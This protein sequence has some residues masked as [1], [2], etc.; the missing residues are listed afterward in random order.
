MA[1]VANCNML[2]ALVAERQYLRDW[3]QQGDPK[4]L[5]KCLDKHPTRLKMV[6]Y[7]VQT[8]QHTPWAFT[9]EQ[10]LVHGVLG[11]QG[12]GKGGRAAFVAAYPGYAAWEQAMHSL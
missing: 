5:S 9:C 12:K 2:A 1:F 3:L 10:L 11:P 4:L 7:L 6:Q 8:Q